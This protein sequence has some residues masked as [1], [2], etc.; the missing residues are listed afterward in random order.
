MPTDC[1][2]VLYLWIP[3]GSFICILCA[4]GT[5]YVNL[6]CSEYDIASG[7]FT[8]QADIYIY[9]K[10]SIPKRNKHHSIF[11][12]KFKCISQACRLSFGKRLF[13]Y[14]HIYEELF[15]WNGPYH[16]LVKSFSCID[17]Y[18]YLCINKGHC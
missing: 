12:Q 10:S 17:L 9:M 7:S 5:T 11:F 1:E 3:C 2:G 8:Y 13:K 14:L 6:R 4:S 15:L 16:L 18:R